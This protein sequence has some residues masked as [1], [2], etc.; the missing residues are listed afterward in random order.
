MINDKRFRDIENSLSLNNKNRMLFG[1]AK[2]SL[3]KLISEV[4]SL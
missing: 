4:K 1:D 2:D 3:K